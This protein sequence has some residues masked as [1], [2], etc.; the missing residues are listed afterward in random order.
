MPLGKITSYRQ[1]ELMYG[2]NAVFST[3]E[4]IEI[5]RVR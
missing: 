1:N 2:I 3:G 5:Q 4:G